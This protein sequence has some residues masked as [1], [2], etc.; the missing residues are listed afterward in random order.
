M[1]PA[2][3][4]DTPASAIA[5]TVVRVPATMTANVY[6]IAELQ[7]RLEKFWPKRVLDFGAGVGVA[8][9]AA[10]RVFR[11]EDADSLSCA[12]SERQ[13][14]TAEDC[15]IRDAMLVDHSSTMRDM[16]E[17]AVKLDDNLKETRFRHV[18]NLSDVSEKDG[19]YDLVLAS[20][21]LN[22]I[23][24]D[25]MAKPNEHGLNAEHETDL[26]P[27]RTVRTQLAEKR[28]KKTVMKLWDKTAPGGV[29]VIVEDGTAAGFEVVLFARD[30]ILWAARSDESKAALKRQGM[31]QSTRRE[32]Q[33]EGD[34]GELSANKALAAKIG[35]RVIAPCM[36]LKQCPL[37]GSVTRHRVCRFTQRFNRPPFLRHNRP[38]PEGFQDEFFSYIVIQ[39]FH[40]ADGDAAV[41][42]K[43]PLNEGG[44]R[45]FSEQTELALM[46]KEEEADTEPE[47]WG[48]LIRA[49]LRRGK[50]IALDACTVDGTLERRVVTRRNSGQAY[51]ALAR[52]SRWGD[53][54][55][56]KPR[57]KPQPV[58]F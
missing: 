18:A 47:P 27:T 16:A 29:F 36:H 3:Q 9:M 31:S 51:Y 32:A 58:N 50:H 38:M 49:P 22:E 1:P 17:Q 4:Y 52:R 13:R 26:R 37:L 39:K 7:R 56:A 20:Y 48:R 55:P 25:A 21:S 5:N 15:F 46:Q 19:R 45:D 11:K 6:V 30:C 14:G 41:D 53:I 40:S 42:N 10:G 54:W 57:A 28:L 24:R 43:A 12:R 35:A 33:A 8:T 44:S 23:V 34:V 2:P